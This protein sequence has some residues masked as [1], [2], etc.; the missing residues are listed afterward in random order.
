MYFQER[1]QDDTRSLS[2]RNWCGVVNLQAQQAPGNWSE[3]MTFNRK[4]K[5]GIPQC[6]N[7]RPSIPCEGLQEPVPKDES[8]RRGTNTRLEDNVLIWGLFLSTTMKAAVHLG[9]HY[10]AFLQVYKNTNFEEHQNL[11]DITQRFILDH[12]AEILNAAPIDWTAPPWTRCTL[13]HDQV[14]TRTKAKVHVYSDSVLCLGK[15]QEHSEANQRWKN[16]LER[17]S[18][19]QFLQRII[20]N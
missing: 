10:T 12:H 6:V 16:Q 8:R 20:W 4:D 18:T 11:F 13:T 9:P 1:Q 5:V 7:L 2:T 15:I 3:V 17:I 19:L 14:I